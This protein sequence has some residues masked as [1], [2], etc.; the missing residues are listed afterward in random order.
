[1]KRKSNKKLTIALLALLGVVSAGG[2]F[3]YW[4]GAILDAGTTGSNVVTIG[5]AANVETKV[6]IS[7][8]AGASYTLVPKGF[9][10][11][12]DEVEF[13]EFDYVVTWD[14]TNGK[15][16]GS[17]GTGVL[18]ATATPS[19]TLVKVTVSYSDSDADGKGVIALH[20]TNTV[21]FKFTLD[22]PADKAAYD[23]IAG[24]NVNVALNFSVKADELF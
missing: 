16:E 19:N 9:A 18:T 22:V 14:N 5:T 21:T 12:T 17:I 13:V 4:Q 3:A 1:M 24:T 15:Y 23:A 8:V 11:A 10:E 2:T 6:T 7:T 20:G